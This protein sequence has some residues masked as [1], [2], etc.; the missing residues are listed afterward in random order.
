MTQYIGLTSTTWDGSTAQRVAEILGTHVRWIVHTFQDRAALEVLEEDER[1]ADL[2]AALL[3]A[4]GFNTDVTDD[5]DAFMQWDRTYYIAFSHLMMEDVAAFIEA[6]HEGG[7]DAELQEMDG[8][9]VMLVKQYDFARAFIEVFPEDQ[10]QYIVM[11][12]EERYLRNRL[13]A[14]KKHGN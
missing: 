4:H 5:I 10:R 7:T 2:A 3:R 8:I 1:F 6:I 14:L 11:E 13:H 12:H 9:P